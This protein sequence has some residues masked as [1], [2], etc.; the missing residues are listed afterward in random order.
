MFTEMVTSLENNILPQAISILGRLNIA[1]IKKEAVL[2]L[3][4]NFRVTDP[5]VNPRTDH[6]IWAAVLLEDQEMFD[7]TTTILLTE[8][9]VDKPLSEMNP[10]LS[11]K[12]IKNTL[13]EL[14]A[15]P[16][17]DLL[18][19]TINKAIEKLSTFNMLP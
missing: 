12:L 9:T 16:T 3:P 2:Q 4:K 1:L 6:M 14:W 8:A 10:D 5:K 7:I 15:T 11:A 13:K 17:D 19:K 18:K